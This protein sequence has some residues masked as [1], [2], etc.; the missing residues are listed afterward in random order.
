[1]QDII[2]INTSYRRHAFSLKDNE[3]DQIYNVRA[4]IMK[5]FYND[6]STNNETY[7]KV[8]TI[9]NVEDEKQ[10]IIFERND[11]SLK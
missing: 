3:A 9:G 10:F 2:I 1:M 5:Q 8:I 11:G 4:D 7:R 6:F